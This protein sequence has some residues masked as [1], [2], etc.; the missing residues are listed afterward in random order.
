MNKCLVTKLNGVIN[1]SDLIKL[2]ELVITLNATKV[3]AWFCVTTTDKETGSISVKFNKTVS[4]GGGNSPEEAVDRTD[5]TEKTIV[6]GI[7]PFFFAK[8]TGTIKVSISSKF[9]IASLLTSS[10]TGSGME[11]VDVK[12]FSYLSN[13]KTIENK[14]G[15]LNIGTLSGFKS[16]SKVVLNKGEGL[17]KSFT[18]C[19]LKELILISSSIIGTLSDLVN[20]PT[21]TDL[22]FMYS[23]NITGNISDLSSLTS[24][25]SLSVVGTNITGT[26]E[27]LAD[28]MKNAGRKSGTLTVYSTY[29]EGVTYNGAIFDYL[30]ITFSEGSYSVEKH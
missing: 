1:N 24:L 7:I 21:L 29:M 14:D 8:E 19:P 6:S 20:I 3:G 23:K 26:I 13:L 28:G 22:N 12:G 30:V 4:F 9:N 25:E 11:I 15:N 27:S 16:L 5:I 2:D 17:L 10:T 18:N